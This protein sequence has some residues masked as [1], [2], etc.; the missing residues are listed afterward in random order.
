MNLL[1]EIK[2]DMEKGT[3]GPWRVV[4]DDSGGRWS[5]WPLCIES[6]SIT[7]KP[8][9]RAGGQWPYDWDA[10][11]SQH[12]ACADARRMARAPDMEEALM[13]AEKL[14]DTLDADMGRLAFS[15][16]T[17]KALAAFRAATE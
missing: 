5:G 11:T 3:P 13:A 8:I 17:I 16:A 14:V 15:P 12:E 4:I 10:K 6:L 7:D 9:A 1:D 2:K